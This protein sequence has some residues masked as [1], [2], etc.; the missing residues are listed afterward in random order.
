MRSL[1]LLLVTLALLATPVAAQAPSLPPTGRPSVVVG[2]GAAAGAALGLV[3]GYRL[4]RELADQF[5][6]DQT[7]EDPGFGEALAGAVLGSVLGAACGAYLAG[8]AA[9][10]KPPPF[11]RRLRDAGVGL[12]V[13]GTFGYV[14]ARLMD[15]NAERG[16][17]VGV[18]LGN[19]VYAGFSNGRW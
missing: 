12:L 3:G 10:S 17:V 7:G 14:A 13:A 19:G 8:E 4:G 6:I 18:S 11:G 5:S 1:T 16:W 2:V 9:G 15:P